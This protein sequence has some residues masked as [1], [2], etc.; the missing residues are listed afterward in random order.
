MDYSIL[1]GF[2][3]VDNESAASKVEQKIESAEP[4]N[5]NLTN[6]NVDKRTGSYHTPNTTASPS[7]AS[8]SP[9]TPQSSL[10]PNNDYELKNPVGE[11][12]KIE[13]KKKGV[14]IQNLTSTFSSN[15]IEQNNLLRSCYQL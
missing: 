10:S 14:T 6:V 4:T 3:F 5:T 7:P 8:F 13:A 11:S 15:S 1:L 9:S 12:P 2:H